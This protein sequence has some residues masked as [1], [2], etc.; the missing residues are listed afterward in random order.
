MKAFS[1]HLLIEPYLKA[2]EEGLSKEF[3]QNI[4]DEM[5]KRKFTNTELSCINGNDSTK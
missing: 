1:N 4:A 5:G 2:K 3:I